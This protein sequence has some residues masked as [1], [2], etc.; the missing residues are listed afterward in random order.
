MTYVYY[1]NIIRTQKGVYNDIVLERY[2]FM[3][4]KKLVITQKRFKGET[5]VLSVRLPNDM[6]KKFDEI[7]IKTGRNR[8]EIITACLEFAISHLEIQEIGK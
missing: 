7:A 8:N 5:A 3:D 6:I 2:I 1:C 4:D